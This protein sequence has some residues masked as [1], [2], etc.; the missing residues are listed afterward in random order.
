MIRE[1]RVY[2]RIKVFRELRGFT[3]DF[4]AKK[5][6]V[7]IA[8]Y[9]AI[10]K[11]EIDVKLSRLDMIAEILNVGFSDFFYSSER[12]INPS[13]LENEDSLIA[14]KLGDYIPFSDKYTASYVLKLKTENEILSRNQS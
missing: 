5:L 10:E 14:D 12:D 8:N 9:A 3:V 4:V 1:K 13:F 7:S 6:D 11:G 2:Y